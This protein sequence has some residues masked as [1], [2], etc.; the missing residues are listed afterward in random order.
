MRKTGRED[1]SG[2][3]DTSLIVHRLFHILNVKSRGQGLP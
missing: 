3:T 1:R 2:A